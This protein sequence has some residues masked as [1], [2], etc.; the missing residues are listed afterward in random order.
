[1]LSSGK[2]AFIV[3][4][5]AGNGFA[6]EYV[7]TVQE[8]IKRFAVEGDIVF[9][10]HMG[11]ARL[12][13]AQ[14]ARDGYDPVIVVGGDGTVNEAAHGL[15]DF[16]GITMGV[17]PAGTGN[18]FIQ[19]LGFKE[20]FSEADWPI[21]FETHKVLMDVGQCNEHIFLNGM[22]LGFDAQVAAENYSR[23]GEVKSGSKSKYFWHI[24]KNLAFFEE[25]SFYLVDQDTR[26]QNRFFMNTISIGRRFAGGYFLTPTA[27]A[28]DGFLD[29]CM[30]APLSL[31]GRL[32][33]FLKVPKGRHVGHPKV[34]YY[35]TDKLILE[36][37][38]EVPHHLDGELRF[39]KSFQI[40]ILPQKM[41]MIY[42]PYGPH[43]FNIQ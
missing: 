13:S 24:I 4:P 3:N 40:G 21:F 1:M 31:P 8:Q 38:E 17:I 19:I 34:H 22:G 32:N 12:L 25:K 30:V 6:R 11:H 16:P 27:I 43:Y 36:F 7:A 18:D 23:E 28:N 2:W 42:N 35:Q 39:A 10:E 20:R 41:N 9:T 14:L 29:I 5:V 37:D 15:L 33:L 26:Q